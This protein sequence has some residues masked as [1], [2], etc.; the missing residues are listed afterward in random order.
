MKKKVVQIEKEEINL[1]LFTDDIIAYAE[2]LKESTKKLL[3][4]SN[5][6]KVEGYKVNI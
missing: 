2:N 6:G 1:S 3:E 4:L 5:H